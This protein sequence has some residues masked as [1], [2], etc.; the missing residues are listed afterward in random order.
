MCPSEPFG[1]LPGARAGPPEAPSSLLRRAPAILL[2]A[3]ALLAGVRPASAQLCVGQVDPNTMRV[4]GLINPLR[5]SKVAPLF[6]WT[7]PGAGTQTNWQIQLDSESDFNGHGNNIWFWESGTADKGALNGANQANWG[8]VFPPSLPPRPLD[9]R[10]DLIYWRIRT[11]N[12]ND[13]GWSADPNRFTCA[14]VK[15]NQVPIPPEQVV[16]AASGVS[17]SQGAVVFPPPVAAPREFFVSTSGNDANAGTQAQ[18]FRTI[19]RGVRDLVPGDTLSVRAGTYNENVQIAASR[20]MASGTPGNPITVRRFPGDGPVIVRGG[21][22]GPQ[23]LS[24]ILIAGT[25]TRAMENWI[26]DGLTI[27]GSGVSFGAYVYIANRNTLKNLRFESTFNPAGTGVRLQGP[28]SDNLVLD[29]IFNRPMY[30]Q[31]EVTSAQHTTVR[32]NE[33]TNG[34]GQITISFHSSASFAGIIEDN[35]IHDTSAVEGAIQ[36]Y[37][38]ADGAVVRNNLFY[39]ITQPSNG[40]TAAV[41]VMRC[42]KVL[43]EN[44]TMVNTRRGVSFL[45]FSRFIVVRNNIIANSQIGLDFL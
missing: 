6:S 8:A 20:G 11:Q 39:N 29:S 10:A 35:V 41:Q 34:N 38:S 32:G 14:A 43:I 21:V 1:V 42:G 25:S 28:A 7:H 18:P 23:P 26:V 24:T 30:Y 27:G 22:S 15:L 31:L 19:N 17:G 4:E 5:L 45:E 36:L 44:N 2:V 13:P 12:N 3:A 40:S 33:F 37:L 9:T 16:V